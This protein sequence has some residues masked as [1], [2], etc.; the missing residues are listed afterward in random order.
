LSF[1]SPRTKGK[2]NQRSIIND[3]IKTSVLNTS[4]TMRTTKKK[5][6]KTLEVKV[7]VH[8]PV[9]AYPKCSCLLL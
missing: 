4:K 3:I 1:L 9:L 2:I 8:L 6:R 5:H 7:L